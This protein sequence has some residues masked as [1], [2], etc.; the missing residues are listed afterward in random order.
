MIYF[1]IL[2]SELGQTARVKLLLQNN[3]EVN[4]KDNDGC[5]ALIWGKLF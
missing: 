5:T 1:N 3:N 4:H 2:A